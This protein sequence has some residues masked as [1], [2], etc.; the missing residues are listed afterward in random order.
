MN[1]TDNI[2]LLRGDCLE[3]LPTIADCSCDMALVD[4]S[5]GCL[6]KSNKH[7][8]WDKELPLDALWEQWKR[9]VKPNGAIVL[10]GQGMFSAKL[11]L[12][13]PKL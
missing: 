13:Q 2:T 4:L 12:S 6:N 5:Y 7:A 10:F 1:K 11:M 8:A 3:I 9:I